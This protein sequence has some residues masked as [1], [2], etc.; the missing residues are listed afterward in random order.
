MMSHATQQSIVPS[1]PNVPY[2]KE[3]SMR[4]LLVA[5]SLAMASLPGVAHAWWDQGWS[6]RKPLTLDTTTTG[7]N[8]PGE[9]GRLPM[10]VRLHDGNMAFS[11]ISEN[12]S[13]IRF[14]AEDDKT[15]LTYH[16]ESFD[17]LLGVATIWVDVP[18]LSGG[19]QQKVWMYFGNKESPAAVDTP[20]TYDANTLL[21]YH[22]DEQAGQPT[23]DKTAFKSDAQNG[24]AAADE[25][26]IIGRGAKFEGGSPIIVE[27]KPALALAAGSPLTVSLWAKEAA[28][29]ANSILFSRGSVV[30]GMAQGIPYATI[31]AVRLTAPQAAQP[32]QWTH[33]AIT[34]DGTTL[35][36]YVNGKQAISAPGT[37]PAM[38]EPISIGGT[39]AA[40]FTGSIDELRILKVASSPARI[41]SENAFEGA[42]SPLLKFG[43][44]EEQG[45]GGG[46]LGFIVSHTPIADWVV[47]AICMVM[48]A[49]AAWVM[50]VKGAY[51]GLASKANLI[52]MK[53]FR[54]MTGE[55]HSIERQP[56]VSPAELKKMKNSPLF[57]LYE[58]GVE[59]LE[60]RQTQLKGRALS[61]EN[62][63]AIRAAIDATQVEENQKL[64]SLMV[65]LTIAIAGGPFI[66]LLGTV[67][68]VMKT[69]GG[70]A[71]AGDV[72]INAIAPGIAA[73]LLA[74]VA[75]LA[76]AIPALFGYNYLNSQVTT[77][78]D[79]MRIF[80]DRLVTRLAE[81]ASEHETAPPPQQL[82]A[83]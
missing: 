15:P 33:L 48:L 44:D 9:A 43:E 52:F 74:T 65:L 82:A 72:N 31:G 69:F 1:R 28:P 45:S 29:S 17:G 56:D 80:V 34:A 77:I 26:A 30:I 83:E 32:N 36:L 63:E 7:V 79:Q 11:D 50:W 25:S 81:Q 57:R 78:S 10:L 37:T 14:I 27:A 22:F 6:Y 3:H 76:C 75:G 24:P 41:L 40:P 19:A 18:A 62:I 35:A 2:R 61:S 53:H 16:I 68:G 38:N 12:G 59:E 46:V 13:D 20:G 4:S 67:I 70:V 21:V 49:I 42:E 60:I 47:I 8:V 64:D 55:L 39:T 66:G 71:L 73:A 58:T 51:L 23:T 5:L 54:R